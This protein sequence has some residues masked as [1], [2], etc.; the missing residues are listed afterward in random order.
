[1]AWTSG[2]FNSVNGDR[3]YNSDQLS[4]IF[5]GLITD[6]VY[7]SVGNKLAVQPNNG[8]TIQINT[9]RGWFGGRWV[10][11]DSVYLVTLEE[12]DVLLNRYCAVCVRVNASDSSRSA[13][14]YLKYSEYATDPVKPSMLRNEIVKEY[15]LA[16]VLIKAGAN[17]ITAAD[18]EDARPDNRVCG[19]VTGLIEQLDTATLWEQWE[20]LFNGFMSRQEAAVLNWFNGLVNYLDENAAV[21]LTNDVLALQ[22]DMNE[23]KGRVTVRKGVLLSDA[24]S[25]LS[26]GG[27]VQ[28]V[29]MQ[30]LDLDKY[31]MVTPDFVHSHRYEQAEVTAILQSDKGIT[32]SCVEPPH[33][34]I[35]VVAIVYDFAE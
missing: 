15:C 26:S 19:W 30:G 28:V 1:M 7:A 16:Y 29:E 23:V 21:K 17:G 20:A 2:F 33:I 6:G 32:F 3:R 11:N 35:N 8:M 25:E 34:D 27:Y 5:N 13:E 10:N 9:G 4:A 14:P 12:P 18:I 24:W 22:S 31:I